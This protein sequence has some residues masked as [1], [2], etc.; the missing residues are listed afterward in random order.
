M[1]LLNKIPKDLIIEIIKKTKKNYYRL[2]YGIITIY[3]CGN[4][5]VIHEK[6]QNSPEIQKEI[7]AH[8]VY[9]FQQY[10]SGNYLA[11]KL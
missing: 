9:S 2:T 1:S 6:I 4:I 7:L 5:G 8:W 10:F 3:T 11:E